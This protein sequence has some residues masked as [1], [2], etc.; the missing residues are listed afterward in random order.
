MTA[1][2]VS[3]KGER[4]VVVTGAGQGIGEGIVTRLAADEW[5]VC[6]VDLPGKAA[7]VAAQLRE[8]GA[9][10]HA[11]DCDLSDPGSVWALWDHLDEAGVVPTA[12]VNNAGIFPRTKAIDIGLDEWNRVLAV[13][14]T[15]GFLMAQAFARRRA[16]QPG[17]IVAIASGQ[18]LRPGPMGAHYAASKGG[19]L[20]LTRAL[21]A[22]WGP[23]GIRMNTVIPGV[24]DTAQPRAVLGDDDFRA[25]ASAT[26]LGR[27]AAPEDIAAAVAYLLSDDAHFVHGQMLAVNGGTMMF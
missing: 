3:A 4:C 24:V 9:D 12:L 25:M 7:P 19:I 15:G 5:T 18:A 22:E 1:G 20:N 6:C 10:A 11:A 16:G 2:K 21:A 27:L 14:L 17:A 23:L 26:P 13:N 8:A